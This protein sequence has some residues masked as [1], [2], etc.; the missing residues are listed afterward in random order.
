[1]DAQGALEVGD[2]ARYKCPPRPWGKIDNVSRTFFWKVGLQVVGERHY[3]VVDVNGLERFTPTPEQVV[4]WEA[5]R[6]LA[7]L[8][9]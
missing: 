3:R 7:E 9:R 5:Y 1:M 2:W 8:S 4:E 6:M